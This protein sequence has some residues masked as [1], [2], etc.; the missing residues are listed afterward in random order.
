MSKIVSA[1]AA[2]AA[3]PDG[4]AVASAG[5]IGW[6]T[7]DA[8]L[9]A[10][11]RRFAE[12]GAPRGL[13][14]YFPCGTGDAMG[15]KG[16]DHVAREGLMKRIVA[17]SFINPVDPATGRRP[18]LMRLIRENRIEAYS[19]PIGASMQWLREVARKSP[20][21]ITRVGLGTY[22][23]PRH[24]GGRFTERTTED[25][26]RVIEID[27]EELLYYP[28]WPLDV[29]ILRAASADEHGNLSWEDEPLTTAN[30]ALA[31]AVKASGGRVI[32]QVRRVV[33]A[34][35]RKAS[36]VRLPGVYVDQVV[37]DP[38]MMMTT[39]VRYEPAYFSGPRIDIATLSPPP[40]SAD[41]IIANRIVPEVRPHELS[42]FGFGAATDVPLV[43]AEQGLFDDGRLAD[44]PG[45]TEHGAYGGVV[46]PGWQFSA[47]INPDA[48]MDG[49]TQFDA[50][51][52]GLCPFAA[53][54]FAEY[55]ADGVVNVSK[56]GK[57]NPGAG[58]F[59]DIAQNARRL[60][61]AGTFTTGGLQAEVADGRLAITREGK[62]RKFVRAAASITYR[63]AE[64]V[65]IRGQEALI[66]TE[67][68]VFRAAADGLELIEIA[69]GIDL[70]SQ[71]LDL[72]DFAPVRIADPLPLMDAAHFRQCPATK[73]A[74]VTA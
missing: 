31:L 55:D 43:M 25:L 28:T 4:A 40:F 70:Q 22:A 6:V 15:I 50:I 18:E 46:M 63:V 9:G 12:T 30:T 39:G 71:V 17:G 11:G 23:D 26:V 3:I 66:V 33:E 74:E 60:I 48:I 5:V 34:G 68:A 73:A 29:A 1:D 69:P 7:P 72:M 64:G 59:I 45:T 49:V 58:G 24:G 2:V 8:V 54:S 44:Y 10:L 37:V 38:E 41:R 16:M 21:Y 36:D 32:A 56:F 52:G 13:T 57:A 51:D 19:W 35:A 67:R 53:L 61:F 65:R 47:N 62:V 14:F 27:G 42:I 20:G